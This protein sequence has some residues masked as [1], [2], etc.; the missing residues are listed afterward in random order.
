VQA[1]GVVAVVDGQRLFV[2]GNADGHIYALQA[3]TGEKVWDFELSKG[4]INSNPVVAGEVAFVGHSEENI[5]QATLGRTM[6]IDATGRG[7]VTATHGRWRRDV[8]MGFPSALVHDG[9]VYAVDNSANMYALDAASGAIRWEHNL[10]TVGKG[11]PVWADGKI[12][13]SETNGNLHILRPGPSGA[14]VLDTEFLSMPSGDRYAEIY[15]SPAIAYG[16]IYFT[17]EEGVYCLGRKDAPFRVTAST[18]PDLGDEVEGSM[19][20]AVVKVVPGDVTIRLG[21]TVDFRVEAFNAAGRSLGVRSTQW[22]LQGLRGSVDGEGTLRLESEAPAQA[23]L[24][25]ARVGELEA[26]ARVRVFGDLPYVEDFES[27]EGRGRSYWIGAGR[28]QVA[29]LDG[30]K[31]LE[32]PVAPSGLLRSILLIG[33]PGL[34]DYSIQAEVRGNQEGRRRTD[35]GVVANGYIL[36]LLGN[37]QKLQL[38]SWSAVL[39]MAETIDFDWE[40]GKWYVMKL[41]V[42]QR[43]GTALVRG[44]V[45]PRGE[46]EPAE[47]TISAEDPLPVPAGAPGVIGYSPASIYYDN[48]QVR[49]NQS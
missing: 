37:S 45:W 13:V 21:D 46:S 17:T 9:T 14:D 27:V 43:D 35:V 23:G 18:Y 31:V 44:K 26:E 24:V 36:D 5:D 29:T 20:P 2:A 33:P 41:E 3:R 1:H 32:K 4:G 11:S 7:N 16:R 15:G 47:W 49:K 19:E 12:Y 25:K 28:Y 38:R 6:A 42:D 40:M 39:R 8:K 48:I 22:S 10:G 34:S 30:G